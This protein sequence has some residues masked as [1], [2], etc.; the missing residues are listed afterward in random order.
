MALITLD[1]QLTDPRSTAQ[2]T[3]STQASTPAPGHQPNLHFF[4]RALASSPF[5]PKIY[6]YDAPEAQATYDSLANLTGRAGEDSLKCLKE[7]D[8]EIIREA[9]LEISGSYVR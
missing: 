3:A 1:K 9:A 5:W 7:V 6:R 8:V 4:S 2:K